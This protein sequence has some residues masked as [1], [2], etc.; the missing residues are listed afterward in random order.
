MCLCSFFPSN[1]N[2]QSLDSLTFLSFINITQLI[3][4]FRFY[5]GS[6]SQSPKNCLSEVNW[7][8]QTRMHL[9]CFPSLRNHLPWILDTQCFQNCR[10]FCCC[11]CFCFLN[12]LF[13]FFSSLHNI[14]K[15]EL[16]RVLTHPASGGGFCVVW[17]GAVFLRFPKKDLHADPYSKKDS[18]KESSNTKQIIKD[19]ILKTGEQ[20]DPEVTNAQWLS[21]F[22]FNVCLNYGS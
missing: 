21:V 18:Q 3:E 14:S 11:S 6:S 5:L 2:Q 15:Q 22:S 1:S 17:M 13:F 7:D 19:K 16:Q 10:M 20:A 8:C 4:S 12:R 9:L